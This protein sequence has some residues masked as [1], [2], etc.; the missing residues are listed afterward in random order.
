M[1]TYP[2]VDHLN[3]PYGLCAVTCMGNFDHTRGGH[4]VLWDLE[5]V[6]Q[7]P[8]GSTILLPSST[9]RHSNVNLQ[10]GETRHSVTFYTAGGLFRWV[11][12]G[13]R[14]EKELKAQ[15]PKG[16]KKVEAKRQQRGIDAL[17]LFSTLDELKAKVQSNHLSVAAEI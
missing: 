8:S 9:L 15:N 17:Q 12:Y 11:E 14:T 5:I 6:I 2:H 4:L 1:A 13:C 16:W 7:F 3:V 10:E